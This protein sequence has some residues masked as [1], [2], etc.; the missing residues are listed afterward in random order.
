MQ[1]R[2]VGRQRVTVNKSWCMYGSHAPTAMCDYCVP[3]AC[4]RALLRLMSLPGKGV[5]MYGL[6]PPNAMCD[7]CVSSACLRT[8][9]GLV[10]PPGK[11]SCVEGVGVPGVPQP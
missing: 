4:L 2:L 11:G 7:C 10:S 6:H 8:L 5:C 9:L 3:S 1:V